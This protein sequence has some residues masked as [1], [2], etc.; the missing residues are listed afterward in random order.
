MDGRRRTPVSYQGEPVFVSAWDIFNA[1]GQDE[2]GVTPDDS[3]LDSLCYVPY[4]STGDSVSLESLQFIANFCIIANQQTY[5][6]IAVVAT[7]GGTRS[8]A[9]P[10]GTVVKAWRATVEAE[11]NGPLPA[12]LMPSSYWDT[13][14]TNT[15]IFF[16][17]WS[18]APTR[19]AKVFHFIP[20]TG[21]QEP[22]Q[23]KFFAVEALVAVILGRADYKAFA[24]WCAQDTISWVKTVPAFCDPYY[25][26]C[27]VPGVPLDPNHTYFDT[28]NVPDSFVYPDVGTA[29]V[30]W[31]MLDMKGGG[32]NFTADTLNALLV[33]PFNGGVSIQ[34]NGDYVNYTRGVAAMAAYSHSLGAVNIPEAA[35]CLVVMNKI[36]QSLNGGRGFASRRWAFLPSLDG[37]IPAHAPLPAP[38]AIAQPSF[39]GCVVPDAQNTCRSDGCADFSASY[40]PNQC[41][42]AP[43]AG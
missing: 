28:T 8:M 43:D 25:F 31:A 20:G 36:V 34:S 23:G 37:S 4:L 5:N 22:W 12:W 18:N 13:I 39:R 7:A 29:F 30:A 38:R 21:A 3:H 11:K 32:T 24:E 6:G 26:Y 9:W 27:Y 1:S 2:S 10:F 19:S 42:A 40:D 33:D 14:L 15:R 16:E 35:G 17:Q 41:S